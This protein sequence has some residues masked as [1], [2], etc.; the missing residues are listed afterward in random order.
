MWGRMNMSPTDLSDVSGATY[1]YLINGQPP[2]ANWT[3]LYRPGERVRLRFINGS[4]MTI[5]DV[6]VPGLRMMVVQTDGND[7]E[8]VTVDEFRISVAETY[9]VVIQSKTESA[10]TIFVQSLDRT[11]YARATLAPKS[12]MTAQVPPMDPRPMLSMVDM[13]MAGMAGMDA[14]HDVRVKSTGRVCKIPRPA[15]A[16]T[17]CRACI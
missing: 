12:G 6:R 8:P 13:G 9:D 7:V 16:Q 3:A 2:A 14:M 1:T 4:A 11:G 17:I 10:F 15:R 5:F